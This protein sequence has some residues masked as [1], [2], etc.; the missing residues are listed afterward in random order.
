MMGC[1]QGHIMMGCTQGHIMMGCIEGHIKMGCTQGHIM[2]GC[3]VPGGSQ[4][5]RLHVLVF[6]QSILNLLK[7]STNMNIAD[8]QL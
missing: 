5:D 8:L 1:T 7:V 3:I 2:M 4:Y 6:G